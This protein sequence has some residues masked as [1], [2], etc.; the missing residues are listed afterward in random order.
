MPYWSTFN[1]FKP[2]NDT[3]F[4]YGK[5][6]R[7]LTT[8]D[9]INT[10]AIDNYRE[11][12]NLRTTTELF[13]SNQPKIFFLDGS[14]DLDT[15]PNGDL[16]HQDTFLTYGQALDFIQF[17]GEKAFVD[18]RLGVETRRKQGFPVMVDYL[19]LN[20][21]LVEGVIGSEMIYPIIL[22]GG[23]QYSEEAVIEI[24]PI[25]NR[26]ATIESAKEMSRGIFAEY[27][28]G[29]M[30]DERRFGHS[31]IEQSLPRNI[32]VEQNRFYLESDAS[33][34]LITGSY[35]V[36]TNKIDIRPS[37]IPDDGVFRKLTPWVDE[38]RN[39][40]FPKLTNTIGLLSKSVNNAPYYTRNYGM[41]DSLLQT[42]DNK[43]AAAG[44]SYYGPNVGYYGTDSIA[45]GGL[46]RGT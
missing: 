21:L 22:N 27:M 37:S 15:A 24:F 42:R 9:G 43:S 12:V 32:V 20:N 34:I 19:I 45:F 5:T 16:G 41:D 39:I 33:Y 25:P 36:V 11:G 28:G 3:G 4:H 46:L 38:P 44:Y 30:D 23:P 17:T 6:N 35:G 18:S 14:Q 29:N 26:L 31:I 8:T 7:N 40:F 1:T 13:R 2:F 10:T